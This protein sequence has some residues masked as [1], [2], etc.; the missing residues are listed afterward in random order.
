MIEY[1]LFQFAA[2]PSTGVAWFV[3]T[4]QLAGMGPGFGHHAHVPFPTR[5][6]GR[7]LRVSLVRRPCDWLASVYRTVKRDGPR[8]N[9]IG[10]FHS[11]DY[12]N[13]DAFIR[14]YL[15]RIPG[16]VGRLYNRYEADTYLRI[17]DMPGAF[18]ELM[19]SLEVNF[20]LMENCWR[21]PKI[22]DTL[23]EWNPNLRRLVRET[24]K[25]TY[26]AYDYYS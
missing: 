5:N 24:E 16:E 14:S 20:L 19:E 17:E 11:L 21:V 18:I 26:D 15:S 4:A 10:L 6:K 13:F 3:Q 9:H 2:P 1:N 23:V 12:D 7:R 22:I 25:E 8:S